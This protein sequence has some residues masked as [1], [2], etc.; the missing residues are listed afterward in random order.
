MK[1][2]LFKA[3]IFLIIL[4]I[5]NQVISLFLPMWYGN[6]L[7]SLKMEYLK[8]N[9]PGQYNTLF[10]GSSRFF[11]DIDPVCFDRNSKF[12]KTK[13]FNLGSNGA[14]N[15]ESYYLFESIL[16]QKYL[17]V[18]Y[19]FLELQNN[20]SINSDYFNT[21]RM[22][23]WLSTN[24][25]LYSINLINA[26]CALP[27]DKKMLLRYCL[28]TYF[29]RIFNIE[30]YQGLKNDYYSKYADFQRKYQPVKSFNGF[31]PMD[32]DFGGR[33]AE[34]RMFLMDDTLN[35]TLMKTTSVEQFENSDNYC[36]NNKTLKKTLEFIDIAEKKGIHLIYIL[37]PQNV[38]YNGLIPIFE[39]IPNK[40]K[41]EL[42]NGSV[43]PEFYL[44][45]HTHALQ[46]L[47]NAGAEIYTKMLAEKF[48][49]IVSVNK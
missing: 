22:K 1:K 49:E 7:F 24:Y 39:R 28:I 47:N 37:S 44:L 2:F 30:L 38:N 42:A 3:L 11:R 16:K 8:E 35:L 19:I 5:C 48:N 21:M 33:I 15:P 26:S 43:Y 34:A 31:I 17:N 40:N 25:M 46:H 23:Y 36:I 9:D 18:K 29:Q 10:I 45:K 27:K 4:I 12:V 6:P 20:E 32:K 41:I 14:Y 13:S